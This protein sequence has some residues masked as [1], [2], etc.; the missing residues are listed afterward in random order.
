MQQQGPTLLP[1]LFTIVGAL[2]GIWGYRRHKR[3]EAKQEANRR[4]QGDP[5]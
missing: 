1:L 2:I 4:Q 5:R 3:N